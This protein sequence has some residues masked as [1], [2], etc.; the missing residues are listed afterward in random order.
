MGSCF[1][2]G[3]KDGY[4]K[5]SKADSTK[6]DTPVFPPGGMTAEEYRERG[7]YFQQCVVFDECTFSCMFH[8]NVKMK[9]NIRLRRPLCQARKE[10]FFL[11]LKQGH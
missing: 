3:S 9:V 7:N 5:M 2:R 11:C 4:E 8:K 1:G 10:P 6:A